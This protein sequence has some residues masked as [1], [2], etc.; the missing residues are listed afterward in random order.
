MDVACAAHW[1]SDGGEQCAKGLSKHVVRAIKCIST[2]VPT[3]SSAPFERTARKAWTA[4]LYDGLA[5]LLPALMPLL[6]D[7]THQ[8]VAHREG[9]EWQGN[10]DLTVS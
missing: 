2:H 4:F 3:L 5:D 10:G 7:A 9:T 1:G 8:Q 6:R